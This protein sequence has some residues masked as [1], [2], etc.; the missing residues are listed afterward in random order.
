MKN[1]ILCFISTIFLFGCA[2]DNSEIKEAKASNYKSI[3][4]TT[5]DLADIKSESVGDVSKLKGE[6]KYSVNDIELVA[7]YYMSE[8]YWSNYYLYKD[9]SVI[10]E[11]LL[12]SDDPSMD[13]IALK[14]SYSSLAGR[15]RGG[16]GRNGLPVFE[17]ERKEFEDEIF[18]L[19]KMT[20]PSLPANELA[21]MWHATNIFNFIIILSFGIVNLLFR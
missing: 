14:S 8:M 2:H 4:D 11:Q 5:G 9:F 1:Y 10:E 17:K 15:L 7:D 21:G 19:E 3:P 13:L 18:E 16:K 6:G 12:D 20:L